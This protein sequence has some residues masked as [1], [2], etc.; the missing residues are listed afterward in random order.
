M[1]N[2]FNTTLGYK[3]KKSAFNLSHE[4]KSTGKFG[5]LM[6]CLCREVL[7]SDKWKF[8][9]ESFT[10]FAPMLAPVMH[11]INTF[12]HYFFV[13]NRIIMP[14]WEDFISPNGV[15]EQNRPI[16]PSLVFDWDGDKEREY[17]NQLLEKYFGVGSLADFLG[18][19]VQHL[20]TPSGWNLDLPSSLVKFQLLPFLAYQ[21]IWLEFY[22]DENVYDIRAIKKRLLEYAK[23]GEISLQEMIERYPNDALFVNTFF[24][25]VFG[26]RHRAF[27]KDYFTSALPNTQRGAEVAIGA[28]GSFDMSGT[29]VSIDPASVE[30]TRLQ[31]TNGQPIQG[32]A[33]LRSSSSGN[34]LTATKD[35]YSLT[36]PQD[37]PVITQSVASTQYV[38][39]TGQTGATSGTLEEGSEI[40]INPVTINELRR[41]VKLQEF[42]EK[43]MRGG[44]R[45]IEQ[46]K[47]HFGVISSDARLD[48]PQFLGGDMQKVMISEVTSSAGTD[49]ATLG[50]Y[51]GHG[52]EIGNSKRRKFFSEEHGFIFC[53]FS[54]TPRT[55]YSQGLEKQ[56][57][58]FDW[59]DYAWPEFA[60]LGEQE[61]KNKE[62]YVGATLWQDS[63]LNEKVFGYQSRY[64]E[65]KTIPS[66]IH[67]D[68]KGNLNYWT[69]TRQFD[70][71]PRLSRDFIE[72]RPEDDSLNRIFTVDQPESDYLFINL[73]HR[74]TCSRPLPKFGVPM[75]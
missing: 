16:M 58:R 56:L 50:E 74:I 24:F 9:T 66:Q 53:L 11:R 5:N 55:A 21:H 57:T 22:A 2:I 6:P 17:V 12:Q 26:M 46:I 42:L 4:W 37:D 1:S 32:Q 18:V 47:A 41:A 43:S 45:L 34:D 36:Y 3:P 67:G 25:D 40:P 29:S 75:L 63:N 30:L 27:E 15:D 33:T 71:T 31:S 51:S 73:Y 62:L 65:Y 19:N 68:F 7:P 28:Y 23:L 70:E 54:C 64:A 20:R 59:L 35:N 60:H 10:R 48:R 72:V 14:N 39:L 44:Y 61:V 49:D 8:S 69:L 38:K 13:P 52:T